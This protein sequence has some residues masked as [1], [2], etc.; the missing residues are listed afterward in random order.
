MGPLKRCRQSSAPDTM[1][2]M[3]LQHTYSDDSGV[4][5]GSIQSAGQ[6]L[7]ELE[8]GPVHL[9]E[10]RLPSETLGLMSRSACSATHTGAAPSDQ[11]G[12]SGLA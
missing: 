10:G 5:R 2:V 9:R 4:D 12:G 1:R 7:D 8:V 3:T 6:G 11:G